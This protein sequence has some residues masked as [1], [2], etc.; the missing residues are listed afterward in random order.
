MPSAPKISGS[1]ASDAITPAGRFNSDNEFIPEFEV[2]SGSAVTVTGALTDTQLRASDV[3]VNLPELNA[4]FS[5]IL[6]ELKKMNL[7]MAL[8]TDTFIENSDLN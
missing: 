6:K 8:I 3:D 2:T 7:Q 1:V 5:A 4:T